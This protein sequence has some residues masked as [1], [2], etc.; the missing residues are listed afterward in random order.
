VGHL[1]GSMCLLALPKPR[2]PRANDRLCPVGDLQLGE[3]VGDIVAHGLRAEGELSRDGGIGVDPG[4]EAQNL[5]LTAGEG[6][7]G[8]GCG[9]ALR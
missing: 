8:P 7:E 5:A 1:N 2:F 6:G 9:A 4:D 3:D